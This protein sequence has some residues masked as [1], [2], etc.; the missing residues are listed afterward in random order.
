MDKMKS[1]IVSLVADP[2]ADLIQKNIYGYGRIDIWCFNFDGKGSALITRDD[3]H[4]FS[5]MG[6]DDLYNILCGEPAD[7]IRWY[8][9]SP[10]RASRA[11]RRK[12]ARRR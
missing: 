7:G 10:S 8:R 6:G 12:G 2:K 9:R 4:E 3:D 1:P 5:S 11:T